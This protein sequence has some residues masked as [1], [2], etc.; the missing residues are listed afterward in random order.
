MLE[1]SRRDICGEADDLAR[2][3]SAVGSGNS[4]ANKMAPGRG[5]GPGA[6]LSEA[7]G[8]S[9]IR[10][11]DGAGFKRAGEPSPLLSM[12]TWPRSR[13]SK[14]RC[15]HIAHAQNAY[16]AGTYQLG[17]ALTSSG[18]RFSCAAGLTESRE[19]LA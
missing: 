1:G 5:G 10:R 14:M 4:T 7:L 15:T 9:R 3:D 6:C 17:R 19:Q 2:H 11:G 16:E 8:G 13:S 18:S 12:R